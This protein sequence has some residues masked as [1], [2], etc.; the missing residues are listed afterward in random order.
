[1]KTRKVFEFAICLGCG[2]FAL[3]YFLAGALQGWGWP[4]WMLSFVSAVIVAMGFGG[5]ARLLFSRRRA[6]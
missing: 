3:A 1:M 2:A 4:F 6:E 5:L